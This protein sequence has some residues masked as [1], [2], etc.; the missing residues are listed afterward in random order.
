MFVVRGR[1][2]VDGEDVYVE[3]RSRIGAKRKFATFRVMGEEEL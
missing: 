3:C 1:W 2:R